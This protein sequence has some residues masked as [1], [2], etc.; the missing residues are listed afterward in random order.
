MRVAVSCPHLE[1][2]LGTEPGLACLQALHCLSLGTSLWV[3]WHGLIL[4]AV[5]SA[6]VHATDCGPVCGPGSS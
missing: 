3:P 6:P 1:G 2:S 5:L 4:C